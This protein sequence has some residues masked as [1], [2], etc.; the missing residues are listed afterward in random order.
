MQEVLPRFS[1]NFFPS[2]VCANL[3]PI[4]E[5]TLLTVIF[6]SRTYFSGLFLNVVGVCCCF[7]LVY[8][9]CDSSL[10]S[11]IWN[12]YFTFL[13]QHKDT[14]SLLVLCSFFRS[15]WAKTPCKRSQCSPTAASFT[16]SS[17]AAK[18]LRCL[19][20]VFVF[21][22]QHK[23]LRHDALHFTLESKEQLL[24]NP[25]PPFDGALPF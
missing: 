19:C 25:D 5:L 1:Y 16:C 22:C 21:K 17:Q 4:P 23:H 8:F 18:S 11:Q 14:F 2:T 9:L 10:T 7:G 15:G 13:H 24:R 20:D 6:K 12:N 3:L